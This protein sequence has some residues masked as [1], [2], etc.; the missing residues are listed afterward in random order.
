VN[1]LEWRSYGKRKTAKFGEEEQ[2]EGLIQ[3]DAAKEDKRQLVESA[4]K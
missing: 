4:A 1:T 3:H 2:Q